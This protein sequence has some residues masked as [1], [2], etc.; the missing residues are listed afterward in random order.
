MKK[1]TRAKEKVSLS[2][3]K[4]VHFT[5]FELTL[6]MS[7]RPALCLLLGELGKSFG[8]FGPRVNARLRYVAK[9]KQ[10]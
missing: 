3:K 7:S 1:D 8:V 6:W 4:N 9:P 5:T 10:A 2:H